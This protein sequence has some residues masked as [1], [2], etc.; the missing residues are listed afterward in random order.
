MGLFGGTGYK[1][2]P[3]KFNTISEAY[4]LEDMVKFILKIYSLKIIFFI[5]QL[6]FEF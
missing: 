5:N 1:L 6:F 2:I 3:S 4:F